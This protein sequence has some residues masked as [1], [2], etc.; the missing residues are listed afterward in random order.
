M[1]E[2]TKRLLRATKDRDA[3]QAEVSRISQEKN[4]ADH[5]LNQAVGHIEALIHIISMIRTNDLPSE[6]Y[7]A[8][9]FI[10]QC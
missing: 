3:A 1:L 7:A 8:V 6:Y 2:A 4:K 5:Q 9:E 10:E